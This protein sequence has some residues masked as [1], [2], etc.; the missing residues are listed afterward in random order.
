VVCIRS[1]RFIR[2]GDF[3]HVVPDDERIPTSDE[4]AALVVNVRAG[5][6]LGTL[7]SHLQDAVTTPMT[8][9]YNRV[10]CVVS[11]ISFVV[12]GT[13]LPPLGALTGLARSVYWR[14]AAY[15]LPHRV[16]L[17]LINSFYERREVEEERSYGVEAAVK[18]SV[19]NTLLSV[20]SVDELD[21]GCCLPA[22][23]SSSS[24]STAETAVA[25]APHFPS[26]LAAV[27]LA[28]TTCKRLHFFLP[29][30]LALQEVRRVRCYLCAVGV[31]VGSADKYTGMDVIYSAMYNA[32]V[33]SLRG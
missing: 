11:R 7:F 27:T 29:T 13:D 25:P 4:S 32:D 24:S 2:K 3:L 17:N 23:F 15:S 31:T 21:L 18:S 22:G 26:T 9:E 20:D 8:H 28:I 1:H 33:E 12:N 14:H 19:A 6:D 16:E 5:D 30:F 10:M